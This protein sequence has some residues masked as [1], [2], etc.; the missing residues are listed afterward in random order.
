[1][2]IGVKGIENLLIIFII[3]KDDIEKTTISKKHIVTKRKG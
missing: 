3:Y 2:Q 1:M